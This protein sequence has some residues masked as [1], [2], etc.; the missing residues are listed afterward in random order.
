[1]LDGGPLLAALSLPAVSVAQGPGGEIFDEFIGGG[2]VGL[3]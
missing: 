2:R 3:N 1:L